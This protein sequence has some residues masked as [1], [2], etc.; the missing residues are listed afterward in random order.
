MKFFLS[1]ITCIVS[2]VA[3]AQNYDVSLIPDSLKENANA[4]TR[5]EEMRIIIKS[6]GKAI[7]KH[8]YVIT[9]LNEKAKRYGTFAAVYNKFNEINSI[10]GT[11][12]NAQGKELKNVKKKDI[13]DWNG[14][15]E[16][17]LIEDTR[18]K[19]YNFSSDVYPYTVKFESEEEKNGIFAFSP[20]LPIA[21]D[22]YSLE[23]SRLKI[24]APVDYLIR[25]KQLNFNDEPVINKTDKT[26]SYQWELKNQKAFK[27]EDYLPHWSKV[28][29]S[30]FIA[31]SA[32]E[33]GGYSG[34]MS[35]WNEFGKYIYQLYI[36]RDELPATIKQDIH[37]LTDGITSREDKIRI[38][39]E[40]MQKN[41]RYISIQLGI[42]GLQP[43]DASYVA[44]KKYGDCKALSN[45][46]VSILKEAGIEAYPV[47]INGDRGNTPILED[48]PS[49]QFNHAVMCVPGK[50]TIWLECT[51]QTES[52]GYMGSFTGNR[53]A[54]LIKED[55]GYL[56]STPRYGLKENLQLRHVN[57]VIDNEGNLKA[58]VKTKYTG[59]QQDRLH[60]V[61][62]DYTEQQKERFINSQINLPTYK[63][64]SVEYKEQKGK[65]PAIDQ[66]L[67]ITAPA[68]ASI[69]GKRLFI[70]PNL[71]NKS[72]DRLPVD[73]P[74]RFD[75]GLSIS[76]KDADTL[77][78]TVPEGYII[79]SL[80]KD[81]SLQEK[82][83]KY[84]ISFKVNDNKIDV[85]RINESYEGIYPK[86]DYAAFAKYMEDIYKADRSRIVLVK[87]E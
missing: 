24:E 67:S 76:Q 47:I 73:K 13:Q 32:F 9:V 46:M 14:T 30:V 54:L 33:Y 65:L 10:D 64:E 78:I 57:A 6:P 61:I 82:W 45:Y 72:N 17:S 31:P 25:F 56:V 58:E 42:G 44:S 4:V 36:G 41:T 18:Y 62:H 80:P 79:E 21:D 5:F 50:D 51:S 52:C 87:K 84:S 53:K 11:L 70:Q 48:F 74:R 83:G 71:F 55:G 66:N 7:I 75:I 23:Y 38:L 40:Y 81:V 86:G 68:Y 28:L 59:I 12:Y 43:F 26:I 1:L 16:I 34:N 20:W 39:Y 49:N 60:F 35:T 85:L 69:T 3:L 27:E 29:P 8:T 37:Q 19:V 77:H 63:V 22:N 15:S 2:T